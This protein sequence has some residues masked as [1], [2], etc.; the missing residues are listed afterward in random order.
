MKDGYYYEISAWASLLKSGRERGLSCTSLGGT[1]DA[2]YLKNAG[3]LEYHWTAIHLFG[4]VAASLQ[5][6]A[7]VV[8]GRAACQLS[9]S[10]WLAATKLTMSLC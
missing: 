4:G 9:C 7:S 1:C 2:G 6:L 3:Y 8:A 5:S 10:S